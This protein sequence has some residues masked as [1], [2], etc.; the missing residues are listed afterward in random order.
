VQIRQVL[1]S[2]RVPKALKT[3]ILAR[4]LEDLAPDRFVRFL[5]AVIRRGRQ[6]I[7]VA[8]CQEYLDLVDQKFNRVH[9]GVT[10]AREPDQSMQEV[11]RRRLGE[12][13]GKEVIPHFRTD[14]HIL[15]GLIVRV[16]DRIMDGSLRRRM[17][18]LRRTLL[19][20]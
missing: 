2:P 16:G 19:G 9:A 4:A 14:P 7:L 15:G 1:D 10:L 20:A 18:T 6:G 13:V 8:I 11:V 12:I 17:A 5:G 3:D